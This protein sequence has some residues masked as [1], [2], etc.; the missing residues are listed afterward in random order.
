MSIPSMTIILAMSIATI[1]IMTCLM[2][3]LTGGSTQMGKE[4]QKGPTMIGA[5]MFFV[6]AVI[7]YW[8]K[9]NIG[10]P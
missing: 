6:V 10:T 7:L 1:A 5:S 4:Q 3:M 9:Q 2:L 8:M